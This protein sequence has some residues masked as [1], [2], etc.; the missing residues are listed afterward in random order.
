MVTIDNSARRG[1]ENRPVRTFAR[2]AALGVAL[3]A[4]AAAG[5]IAY[6]LVAYDRVWEV[7]LPGTRASSDPAVIARG[8]YLVNG[9]GHCADCHSP[10]SA[11]D[12]L[13]AGEMVPLTGGIEEQTWLGDW[14][15]PNLTADTISGIGSL[16]DGTIAR[17]M[18]HGVNREGRI[19]LPFKDSLADLTEEDLVAI[20]SYLR[21]LAPREGVGPGS[22]V[23]IFGK[24]TLAYFIQP[25]APARTPDAMLPPSVSTEYGGYLANTVGRCGSCHT[26]RDL[27]TGE[28]LGPRFSGGLPFESRDRIGT[29]YISPNLTPDPTTGH[30]TDWTEEQFVDRMLAGAAISDSPM[31]WGSYMRM[32]SDDLRAIYRYLQALAPVHRD[33][34]PIVQKAD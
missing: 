16:S 22:D 20:L 2:V 5:A 18:R 9:P 4:L 1:R 14:M 6:A 19:A 30:I 11:R 17:M 24:I 29:T 33:N 10:P 8:E 3:T 28:Y 32:T 27:R 23:N 12:R 21:A 15:A 7:P 26:P 25:Y 31:P 34:G 13:F